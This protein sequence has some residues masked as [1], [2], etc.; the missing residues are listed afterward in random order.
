MPENEHKKDEK[1]KKRAQKARFSACKF[2]AERW[3]T[4]HQKPR[5]VQF[6]ARPPGGLQRAGPRL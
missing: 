5:M 3:R 4:V 6:A 1:K 2:A